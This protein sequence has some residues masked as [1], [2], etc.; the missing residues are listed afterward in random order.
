MD[1]GRQELRFRH[2]FCGFSGQLLYSQLSSD[3]AY[4]E[5]R[6]RHQDQQIQCEHQFFPLLQQQV[7]KPALQY[8][9]KSQYSI[10]WKQPLCAYQ[11][12]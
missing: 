3:L 4:K 12:A 5:Y 8:Q 7:Q 6:Y 1:Q 9:Q 11:N 2:T 10:R